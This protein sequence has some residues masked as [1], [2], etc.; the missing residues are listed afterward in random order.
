MSGFKE[1]LLQ[2][3]LSLE[4]QE[5][6][7]RQEEGSKRKIEEEAK[8]GKERER[9]RKIMALGELAERSFSPILQD[10]NDVYAS[11]R[12]KIELKLEPGNFPSAAA[13]LRLSWEVKLRQS[14]VFYI[15]TGKRIALSLGFDNSVGVA[16]EGIPGKREEIK[17]SD[18]NWEEKVCDRI[19]EVIRLGKHI[20]SDDNYPK[21][22]TSMS[23]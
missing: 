6:A 16:G 22:D 23:H 15:E 20:Y 9:Q 4:E 12:G 11:S 2:L 19:L 3:K 7:S 13:I 21:E 1:R 14:G 17:L 18:E 5:G 8:Q 10:V